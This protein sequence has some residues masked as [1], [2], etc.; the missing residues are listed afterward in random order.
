MIPLAR[1]IINPRLAVGYRNAAIRSD[2]GDASARKDEVDEV[3]EEWGLGFLPGAPPQAVVAGHAEVGSLPEDP[4]G[5]RNPGSDIVNRSII[6]HQVKM[7]VAIGVTVF[8][9]D[10]FGK[11]V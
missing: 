2:P 3:R 8:F 10:R 9:E 5:P 7:E 6:W 1:P 11:L 4:V